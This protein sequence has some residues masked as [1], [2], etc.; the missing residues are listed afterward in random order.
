ME[1]D[2]ERRSIEMLLVRRENSLVGLAT[3]IAHHLDKYAA[4]SSAWN[5]FQGDNL[6]VPLVAEAV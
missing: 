2:A 3:V 5:I 4:C 1:P 6:V